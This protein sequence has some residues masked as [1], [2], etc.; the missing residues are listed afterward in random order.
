MNN[1]LHNYITDFFASYLPEQRN[2]SKN[3]IISYKYTFILFIEFLKD[4]YHLNINKLTFNDFNKD[5]VIAFIE[6]L[7][8]EKG[9]TV[10]TTN[11][12]LC[13]IHSFC[14]YL[15]RKD[16]SFFNLTADILNIEMKKKATKEV[17]Y[18]NKEEI[19]KLFE[20]FNISVNKEL[21]DYTIVSL[22]YDSGARVQELIDLEAKDINFENLTI[23][24]HGKGDKIRIIPI[25][26]QV[27]KIIKKYF[28]IFKITP[29]TNDLL[30]F[31]NRKMKL[32]R[33][34]I[35]FILKKYS[36]RAGLNFDKITPHVLRHTKAMHL[37]ENDIN[38]VY[39]RD[40]LGHKSITTTE[41]Y[42]RAN[43]KVKREAIE[44]LS[45]E[46]IDDKKYNNNKIELLDW[47]KSNL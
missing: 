35:K 9:N 26:S 22:L 30:F 23:R 46:L 34:G 29:N 43:P 3:T 6:Y 28:D 18:L 4:K 14:K 24:L 21:R 40:F 36:K 19:K 42:A 13:A 8:K 17:Y 39:I 16:I 1:Y 2:F 15:Q 11:Q 45:N 10:N 27:I 33:E 25:S 47:L 5:K 31:N 37:L 7:D 20:S 38:I 12:R 41:I 44:N 32:T